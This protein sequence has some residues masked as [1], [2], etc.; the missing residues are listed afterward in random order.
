MLVHWNTGIEVSPPSR[1][2]FIYST[3]P[4]P[5]M[6][7]VGIHCT[8]CKHRVIIRLDSINLSYEQGKLFSIRKSALND[9]KAQCVW[10]NELIDLK[11]VVVEREFSNWHDARVW[12]FTDGLEV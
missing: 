12:L 8:S 3:P 1:Y 6:Q 4:H 11:R 7:I 9:G 5:I 2:I 10:C